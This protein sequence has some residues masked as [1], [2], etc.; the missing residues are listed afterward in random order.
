MIEP[1]GVLVSFPYVCVSWLHAEDW[2]QSLFMLRVHST[3]DYIPIPI[4][5]LTQNYS[6][7]FTI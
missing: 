4:I 7:K 2:A 1:A 3:T 5:V 6:P